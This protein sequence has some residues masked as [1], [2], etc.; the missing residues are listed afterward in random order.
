MCHVLLVITRRDLMAA[1]LVPIAPPAPLYTLFLAD[2]STVTS[3]QLIGRPVV[4]NF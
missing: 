1:A 4:L 3:G 2:G